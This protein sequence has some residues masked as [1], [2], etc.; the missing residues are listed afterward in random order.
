[1]EL[2]EC[3][4]Q[5]GVEML[6]DTSDKKALLVVLL[7]HAGR[8]VSESKVNDIK[9]LI[10]SDDEELVDL[11]LIDFLMIVGNPAFGKVQKEN[12][13]FLEAS[14]KNSKRMFMLKDLYRSV[15]GMLSLKRIFPDSSERLKASAKLIK[16]LNKVIISIKMKEVYDYDEEKRTNNIV[17]C[18]YSFPLDMIQKG[19]YEFFRMPMIEVPDEWGEGIKGGYQLNKTSIVKN[20]GYKNQPKIVCDVVN[21][22]QS[23]AWGLNH[24]CFLSPEVIAIEEYNLIHDESQA[25]IDANPD[26][27]KFNSAVNMA[28]VRTKSLSVCK[29]FVNGYDMFHFQWNYDARGRVYASGYDLNPQGDSYKKGAIVPKVVE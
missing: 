24:D 27:Y 18:W 20:K 13:S 8:R 29:Q 19:R 22:L 6:F 21:A 12:Y 28:D 25:K 23:M 9:A 16:I 15:Y 26:K 17:Y 7:A 2:E 10:Q 4:S 5:Y 3:K 1:M 14:K 11:I